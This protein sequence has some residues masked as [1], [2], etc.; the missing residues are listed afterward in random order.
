MFVCWEQECWFDMVTFLWNSNETIQLADID[1]DNLGFGFCPTDY[2]YVMKCGRDGNFSKGELQRFGNIELSPSSG[3]LNYGQVWP[4][5]IQ[6]LLFIFFHVVYNWIFLLLDVDS[7]SALTKVLWTRK[8][9]RLVC[10]FVNF[11]RLGFTWTRPM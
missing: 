11:N 6:V 4:F 5:F 3:V 1:W 7:Y 9:L 8:V 2:M 10:S